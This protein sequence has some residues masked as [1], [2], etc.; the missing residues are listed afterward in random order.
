MG[1]GRI[2]RLMEMERRGVNGCLVLG[3][4]F[5]KNEMMM[6]GGKKKLI[7]LN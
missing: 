2:Q 1:A 7:L 6:E 4:L 3:G 5:F